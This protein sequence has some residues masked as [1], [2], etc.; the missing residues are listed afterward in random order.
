MANDIDKPLENSRHEL[1]AQAKVKGLNNSQ[2][3][4]KAGYSAKTAYST[5]NYLLKNPKILAR[6]IEL[7]QQSASD[8]VMSRREREERLVNY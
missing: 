2:S 4:I 1:F 3:A 6:I 5:A 7:L 8:A